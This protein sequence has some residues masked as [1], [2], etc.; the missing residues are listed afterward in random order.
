MDM[1][2]LSGDLAPT[3]INELVAEERH[4]A[5]VLRHEEIKRKF[6]LEKELEGKGSSRSSITARRGTTFIANFN[7]PT[8]RKPFGFSPTV[9]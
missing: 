1:R 2:H 6:L 4:Q 8:L 3:E 5:D 9:R 7:V